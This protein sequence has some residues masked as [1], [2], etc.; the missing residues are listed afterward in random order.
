VDPIRLDMLPPDKARELLRG[1]VGDKGTDDE[2]DTV[3]EL[4]AR[5]PLALRVAGTFLHLHA[6]WSTQRYTES[7]R[8]ERLK[9]LRGN[10]TDR[11][12]ETVLGFSAA[13]LVNE[14]PELAK[15]WQML[16]V[17]PSSFAPTAA[18]AVWELDAD[19]ALDELTALL[20]RSLVQYDGDTERYDLHDLMRL[21]A[22]DAFRYVDGHAEQETTEERIHNAERRFAEFYCAILDAANQLYRQG[23]KGVL[24]GLD[25]FD[26]EEPNIRQGWVGKRASERGSL[27][28]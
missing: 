9:R 28:A 5:L 27:S 2:L 22:R 15:R 21:V 6:N 13:I 19:A 23:H 14:K 12:V 3:A 1:I 24:A 18:A 4:C 20:D 17:F 8:K 25:L 7:L 26:G 11:D 16:S 10:T